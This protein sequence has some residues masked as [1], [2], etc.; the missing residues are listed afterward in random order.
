[1]RTWRADVNEEAYKK[2]GEQRGK[3]PYPHDLDRWFC[4]AKGD[5]GCA[6]FAC[7]LFEGHG[8]NNYEEAEEE[9]ISYTPAGKEV[10][11]PAHGPTP[12][13]QWQISA[14]CHYPD[15]SYPEII[16]GDD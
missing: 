14:E 9:K 6:G 1:M 3:R 7:P 13:T 8:I 11:T 2:F 4:P 15:N 5:Y 16:Y 12:A 10:R